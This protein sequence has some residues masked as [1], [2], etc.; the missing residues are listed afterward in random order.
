M[1]GTNNA[2]DNTRRRDRPGSQAIVSELREQLPKTRCSCSAFSPGARSPTPVRDKLSRSTTR[3]PSSTTARTS[4]TSTSARRSSNA[5]GTISQG[6]HARLPS[7]QPPRLPPLGRRHGADA[8]VD[9]RRI[10]DQLTARRDPKA[11][12]S[13]DRPTSPA[14][15][16]T[17]ATKSRAWAFPTG[18]DRGGQL[19]IGGVV[20]LI[21]S[22]EPSTIAQR[23]PRPPRAGSRRSRDLRPAIAGRTL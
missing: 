8:L 4:I 16:D 7:P 12:A 2:S 21:F 22:A 9:A 18:E 3:S 5:D 1:I 11:S 13:A 10:T 23:W 15:L 14:R 17:G 6:D 19:E 20:I